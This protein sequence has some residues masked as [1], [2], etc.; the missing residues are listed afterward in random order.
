MSDSQPRPRFAPKVPLSWILQLYKRDAL[1]IEDSELLDKVGGRLYTR[2][3]D[4]LAVSD[5]L[6]SC[7]VCH[8]VFEV[9][10]IGQPADRLVSCPDCG[11]SISAGVY[12]ASFEHHDLLG[13]NARGA[14]ARYV[15]D[16]PR[17]RRYPERMLI[18]DRLIHAVHAS[19]NTVVR[20]L[21]EGQPRQVLA[22]LDQL[23][24]QRG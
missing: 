13:L 16:Y 17:A 1:G 10:W 9:L 23:A 7:P 20:N 2:C 5:S 4:V 6:L 24:A 15:E 8:T 12:H 11:W 14:F 3:L 22:T 19:G 21:I 18:V